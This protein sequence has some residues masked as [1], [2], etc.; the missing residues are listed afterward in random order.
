[1]A[2]LA[3]TQEMANKTGKSYR[4]GGQIVKP[5]QGGL[6]SLISSLL[7]PVGNFAEA[8]IAA[9]VHGLAEL[10]RA[11]EGQQKFEQALK[12]RQSGQPIPSLSQFYTPTAYKPTFTDQETADTIERG[13]LGD[14]ANLI[15]KTGLQLGSFFAPGGA[16]LGGGLKGALAS[17]AIAG[18]TAGAGASKDLSNLPDVLTNAATGG[19]LGA[20]IGGAAHGVGSLLGK[21]GMKLSKGAGSNIASETDAWATAPFDDMNGIFGKPGQ[22]KTLPRIPSLEAPRAIKG[23]TPTESTQLS[24]KTGA[25]L[26]K[27]GLKPTGT[28]VD[29][30]NIANLRNEIGNTIDDAYA[31]S[32]YLPTKTEIS[33]AINSIRAGKSTNAIKELNNLKS[34]LNSG[35]LQQDP[36]TGEAVADPVNLIKWIRSE[37]AALPYGATST[38]EGV[39][40][41]ARKEALQAIRGLLE[42]KTPQLKG[43]NEEYSIFAKYDDHIAPIAYNKLV[44]GT[45]NLQGAIGGEARNLINMVPGGSEVVGGLGN[46]INNKTAEIFGGQGLPKSLGQAGTKIG[47]GATGI[48][49]FLQKGSS[50]APKLANILSGGNMVNQMSPVMAGEELFG[51]QSQIPSM[52]S[53]KTQGPSQ[54]DLILQFL[55]QGVKPSEAIALA[56]ALAPGSD[57]PTS[58]RSELA[59]ID[60][61]QQK[62]EDLA[63][64]LAENQGNIGPVAGKVTNIRGSLGDSNARALEDQL[65]ILGQQVAK[66]LEGGKLTDA[67]MT[68]Y[69]K[70]L[71]STDKNY[72]T[73]L[74][75]IQLLYKYLEM[76]KQ[77]KQAA[78]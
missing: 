24:A 61:A 5:Q 19:L 18:G 32:G 57:V 41:Q 27:Y 68:R 76:D 34:Q 8:A 30:D 46:K 25:L 52:S 16:Q 47:S 67:D 40:I 48:G 36:L 15:G 17:G 42:E 73:N 62:L 28:R 65:G 75:N 21:A 35:I 11:Q 33:D 45:N 51:G 44:G 60:T 77:N 54:Q 37:E 7:Q 29:F 56:K 74:K 38:A 10:S 78:F 71:P 50:T 13:S 39:G 1:M 70:L 14:T 58:I 69:M 49:Q 55:N 23:L 26:N 2:T 9:P 64:L 43:L 3:Q 72:E 22:A 20:G 66:S 6:Q 53:N 31:K 12:S 4:I 63:S 59:N